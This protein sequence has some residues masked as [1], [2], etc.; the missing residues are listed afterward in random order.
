M[1]D[2]KNFCLYWPF[3]F[4][5]HLF[6]ILPFNK[7]T[8]RPDAIDSASQSE[9]SNGD[10]NNT[11]KNETELEHQLRSKGQIVEPLKDFHKEELR[12]LGKDLGLPTDVIQRH[13]YPGMLERE[14]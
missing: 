9:T 11:H 6:R 14:T 13:P 3:C 4:L 7:G 10:I 12:A 5:L 1:Y 8:L 2:A